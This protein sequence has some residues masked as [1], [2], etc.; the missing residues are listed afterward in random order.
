MEKLN[1]AASAAESQAK[2]REYYLAAGNEDL[3][4]FILRLGMMLIPMLLVIASYIVYRKMYRIDD[5]FYN[6]IIT[7]L[8]TR[9]S[10]SHD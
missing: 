4:R 2:I 7:D 3:I 1:P 5:V 8:S 6:Q 9:K 10:L